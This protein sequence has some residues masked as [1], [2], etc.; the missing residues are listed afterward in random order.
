MTKEDID[1]VEHEQLLRSVAYC[2]ERIPEINAA[3]QKSVADGVRPDPKQR[4]LVKLMNGTKI[5]I[6]QGCQMGALSPQDYMD[7]LKEINMKDQLLLKHFS[8]IKDQP[9]VMPKLRLVMRRV[10]I[11][12][13]EIAEM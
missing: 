6:T 8:V 5:K 13:K 11:V 1:D 10:K 12:K 4:A 9:G 3:L 2:E 7:I